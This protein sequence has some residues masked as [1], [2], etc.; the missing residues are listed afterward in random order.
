M[1]QSHDKNLSYLM[2]A[3]TSL[4]VIAGIAIVYFIFVMFFDHPV[5]TS[6]NAE[7]SGTN[8]KVRVHTTNILKPALVPSRVAF[9]S[10]P[11]S[12]SSSGDPS[13][14][15]CS[16]GALNVLAWQSLSALEPKVMTLGYSPTVSQLDQA[17]CLDANDADVDSSANIAEPIE[18]SIYQISALYYG[19]NFN[20]NIPNVLANDCGQYTNQSLS[21]A[22]Q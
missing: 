11:L 16:N 2:A 22:F 13:P 3:L 14:V 10:S 20:V 1:K 6:P 9:C 17:L 5:V 7:L 19:W 8:N 4:A 21:K 18:A 15:Q 12:Y